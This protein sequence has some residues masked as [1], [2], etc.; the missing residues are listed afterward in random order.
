MKIRILALAVALAMPASAASAATINI[1][2]SGVTTSSLIIAASIVTPAGAPF[3]LFYTFNTDLAAPGN[4][5]N[6]G[7][8]SHLRSV[9]APFLMVCEFMEAVDG[10]RDACRQCRDAIEST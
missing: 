3:S 2:Y 5:T 8:S 4:F 1:G 7:T 6:K 10:G 9:G